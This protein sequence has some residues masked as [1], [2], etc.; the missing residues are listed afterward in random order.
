MCLQGLITSYDLNHYTQTNDTDH[1]KCKIDN[2]GNILGIFMQI[3]FKNHQTVISSQFFFTNI[4]Y[5]LF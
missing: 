1:N 4:H 3:H 5:V 2:S